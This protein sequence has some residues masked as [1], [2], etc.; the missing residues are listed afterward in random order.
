[1]LG[2]GVRLSKSRE[3]EGVAEKNDGGEW[4]TRKKQKGSMDTVSACHP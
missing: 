3:Y 4:A 1:M 2:H